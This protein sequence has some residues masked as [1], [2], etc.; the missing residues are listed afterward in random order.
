MIFMKMKF[1]KP[2]RRGAFTLGL[3]ATIVVSAGVLATSGAAEAAQKTSP[4]PTYTITPTPT[5]TKTIIYPPGWSPSPTTPG[6]DPQN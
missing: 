6:I 1:T 2:A 5:P 3:I 4:T